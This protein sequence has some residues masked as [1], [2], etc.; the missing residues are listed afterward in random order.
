M[1]PVYITKDEY[2]KLEKEL[3]QLRYVERPKIV[4][5]IAK[6]KVRFD[7]KENAEFSAAKESQVLL[8]GKIQRLEYIQA[9]TRIIDTME[10]KSSK[11]N[12]GSKVTLVNLNTG[13]KPIYILVSKLELNIYDLEA[14]SIE[15]QLGKLIIGKSVGDLIMID[16]PAGKFK[17]KIL[18]IM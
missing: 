10:S 15:S 3:H 11:A 17:Y 2:Q 6:E 1:K 12:V 4:Q 8:E 7:V 14:I 13:V 9:R 18:K 5:S 16:K